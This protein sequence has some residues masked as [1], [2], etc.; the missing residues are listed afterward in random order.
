MALIYGAESRIPA[1]T[2]LTNGYNLYDWVMRKSC[3]PSFW[4][5]TL[6]GEGA[7]T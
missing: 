7:L 2:P 1:N 5:R 4:G 3:F 6:T